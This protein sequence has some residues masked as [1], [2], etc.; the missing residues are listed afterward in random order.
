MV[1]T[2]A[3]ATFASADLP[4]LLVYHGS[5]H[6]DTVVNLAEELDGEFT[7]PRIQRFIH[8]RLDRM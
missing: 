6:D 1:A 4:V 7:L 5:R 2:D 3:D 8:K